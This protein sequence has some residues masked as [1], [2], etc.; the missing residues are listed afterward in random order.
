MGG[1]DSRQGEWGA[2]PREGLKEGRE[3]VFRQ[4]ESVSAGV[5][6]GPAWS[7]GKKQ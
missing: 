5:R 2:W 1:E 4:E 3:V 6:V 7:V